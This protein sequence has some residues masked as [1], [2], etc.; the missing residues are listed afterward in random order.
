MISFQ[1]YIHPLGM[2]SYFRYM[3]HK[4]TAVEDDLPDIT[5]NLRQAPKVWAYLSQILGRKGVNASTSG[6]F[7]I[8]DVQETLLFGS[9]T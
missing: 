8:A 7:Y 3:G 5:S 9:E 6:C 2:V 1:A 4:L